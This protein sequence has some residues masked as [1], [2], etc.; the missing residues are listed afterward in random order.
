MRPK[1]LYREDYNAIN[2]AL[3]EFY[4]YKTEKYG[5]LERPQ[6][7]YDNY[8]RFIWKVATNKD[9][10]I[11]DLGSG[12]W[13]IPNTIAKYGF[14]K[15]VGLDYF[16]DQQLEE[17]KKRLKLSNVDLV[18]YSS[19]FIPFENESFDVIS[20]LCVLEHI[21][22][23]EDFLNEIHRVLKPNGKV[24]ILCP[25][26]SGVNAY[27][28]GIFH[29][30]F[31]RDRF[32]QLES[33]IDASIGVIRS[34][35]WYL[36]NLFS[37]EPHYILIYPRIVDGKIDFQRS[38]DDAVHLCQPLSIKKYFKKKGYKVIY[39]NR[40]FGTTPYSYVFN[41]LFPSLATTNVL[42]FQKPAKTN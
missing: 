33:L 13:R 18:K 19:N 35:F 30:L 39:Y 22:F 15:V 14:K 20:S 24:I 17:N 38:D 5:L 9:A 2:Q 21:I 41:F 32:W 37:K 26:W 11:L 42:V 4:T 28:N 34:I 10:L 1:R 12:S 16:T 3:I 36:E 8:G 31:K 27:I 23:V 7:V 6:S 40:G 25:N 29:I